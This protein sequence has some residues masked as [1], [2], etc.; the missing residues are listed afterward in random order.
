MDKVGISGVILTPL[1]LIKNPKGDI[2]HGIK[3]SDPGFSKFGE[4]YFSSVNPGSVKGWNKH[5]KM[6]LNLIVPV[7]VVTF[8]IYD[9]TK[10]VNSSGRF[11]KVELSLDNYLRLTVPPGLWLGFKGNNDVKSLILNVADMEHDPNEMEKK[12]LESIDYPWDLI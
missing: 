1:K 2:Y 10:N 8:V 5:N 6:T 12:E 9:D 4:A 3:R 11:Q 7:G